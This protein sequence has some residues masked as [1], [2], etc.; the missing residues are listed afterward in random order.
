MR[1]VV[2]GLMIAALVMV[3]VFMVWK[4][5][6][7]AWQ[8]SHQEAAR[9]SI[10]ALPDGPGPAHERGASLPNG[11]KTPSEEDFRKQYLAWVNR[12][13]MAHFPADKDPKGAAF[14]RMSLDYLALNNEVNPPR[15][16]VKV[17][18]S[19]S[20]D[21]VNDP[22][23]LLM[24]GIVEPLT[25]RQRT[26]LDKAVALVPQSSY[27]K[28]VWF[29]A[30]ANAGRAAA[31]NNADFDE[32]KTRDALSLKYL[33]QALADGSFQSNEMSVLRWRFSS[34]SMQ[35]LFFRNGPAV[36]S[37]FQASSHVAPWVKEFVAGSHALNE[38]A[39]V[40]NT[41]GGLYAKNGE[42]MTYTQNLTDA[43]THL[44]NAWNENPDD[45]AAA[46]LMITVCMDEDEAT[47]TMRIWF[48][49]AV[50]ADFDYRNA[51][52]R[53]ENGLSPQKEGSYEEMNAFGEECAATGR[54]DTLVPF[55][56]VMVALQ[57]SEQAQDR[58]R[59][60]T[61]QRI[62]TEVLDVIDRYF[63]EPH[64]PI[65]IRF[66]HTAAAIAAYRSG[67]MDELKRHLA[68]LKDKPVSTPQFAAMADLQAMVRDAGVTN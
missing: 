30:A 36:T 34:N 46:A 54:Y 55:Q 5:I 57:I 35:D 9:H 25:D 39:A 27:P 66:A 11:P 26:A 41:S 32:M 6:A 10:F 19:F 8:K 68:A 67:R 44:V 21:Q 56:R 15:E 12:T 49:R 7:G 31:M 20:L 40:G 63:Q 53:F 61:N 59:Q 22:G 1:W 38:A 45:P 24:I 2:A 64:P 13:I 52:T 4:P 48:D 43:R 50:A 62:S 14:M 37:I 65:P 3:V 17:E 60:F 28:Y 23:L 29:L 16:M 18:Q 33:G 42:W 47:E 58:G 51:Y